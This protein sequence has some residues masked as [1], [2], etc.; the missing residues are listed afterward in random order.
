MEEELIVLQSI[1]LDELSIEN[2]H[3]K[4]YLTMNIYANG[5]ENESNREKRLF[6]ITFNGELSENYPESESPKIS[7]SRARGLTDEDLKDL[8]ESIDTC[9]ANN[10]G[11][12]VL[13]E[14]I[15]LIRTKLSLYDTPREPCAICLMSIEDRS[16][17]IRTNCDHFYHR[18]CLAVYVQTKK[19]E[20]EEKYREAS[21]NGFQVDRD[22]R[23]DIED[24]VCRQILSE[25]ILQQLPQQVSIQND[26]QTE[27]SRIIESL[28]PQLRVWQQ[29][30]QILFERQREKG[31]IIESQRTPEIIF[32]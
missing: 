32:S 10:Q 19:K 2:R 6:S 17:T 24:P 31:G 25:N 23:S 26:D 16:E 21:I 1:Y 27:T 29:E 9:L 11:S 8:H 7:L 4:T 12:S 14:C 20:L 3:G 13:Y 30:T 15:E 18:L 28:S 5:D 22:F